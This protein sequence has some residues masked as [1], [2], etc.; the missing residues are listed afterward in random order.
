MLSCYVQVIL[1][2]LLFYALFPFNLDFVILFPA[3]FSATCCA[4][5][6]LCYCIFLTFAPLA[7][8]LD[9]ETGAFLFSVALL[10][11]DKDLFYISKVKVTG[12]AFPVK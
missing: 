3:L 2:H 1:P 10:F 11:A 12:Y 8:L 5:F 4:A 6:T 7:V 9:A